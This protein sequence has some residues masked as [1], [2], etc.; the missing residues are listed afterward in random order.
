[1]KVRK[2]TAF[3]VGMVAAS[4]ALAACGSGGSGGSGSSQKVQ[5]ALV[6][7]STPQGA[8]TKLIKAFQATDAGKNIS[9]TQSYGASGDQSRAVAAG[10]PADIVNFSLETDMTRLVKANLVAADWNA[11]TYKG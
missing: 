5:L 10:L 4:L 1:M 9:F 11:N 6:A 7:Y 3:G 8:Y 2:Y